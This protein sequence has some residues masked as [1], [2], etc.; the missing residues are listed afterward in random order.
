M[1]HNVGAFLDGFVQDEVK[2]R[3]LSIEDF[4]QPLDN[5][6]NDVPLYDMYNRGLAVCEE[7]MDRQNLGLE[8]GR[9]G[10]T[11]YIPSM[12]QGA[13]MGAAPKPKTLVLELEEPSEEMKEESLKRRGLRR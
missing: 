6:E 12:E 2:N 9:P 3:C 7:G 8:P 10:L 5:K 1:Y 4:G 13:A 11:G